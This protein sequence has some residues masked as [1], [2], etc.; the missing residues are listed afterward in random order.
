MKN[1]YIGDCMI[2]SRIAEIASFINELH[3]LE[4]LVK[5]YYSE[6]EDK[7]YE[8]FSSVNN[9]LV[10]LMLVLNDNLHEEF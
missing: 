6:S 10:D 3:D 2:H 7:I 5:C 9:W 8:D 4:K 1:K